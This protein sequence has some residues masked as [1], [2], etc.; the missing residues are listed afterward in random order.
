M[1]KINTLQELKSERLRLM[2]NRMNLEIQI[3]D[4]FQEV[5]NHFSPS[6]LIPEG[7]S[8]FMINKNHGIVNDSVGL[9]V[10]LIVG[11]VLFRNAGFLTKLIVP[12]FARNA[13]SNLVTDNKDKI[14]SWFGN[15]FSKSGKNGKE[16]AHVYERDPEDFYD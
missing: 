14:V 5:K 13:A 1:K 12:F 15:L 2:Q 8:K 11:K 9:L 3:K 16:H 4:D 10:D 7:V 6:R